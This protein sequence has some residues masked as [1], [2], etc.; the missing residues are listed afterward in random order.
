MPDP[1]FGLRED[2]FGERVEPRFYVA[3]PKFEA[4]SGYLTVGRIR[5]IVLV[6]GADGAGKSM[7]LRKLAA[8]YPDAVQH[9]CG[10]EDTASGLFEALAVGRGVSAKPE[11]A[12]TQEEWRRIV[13]PA[14]AKNGEATVL[15][16]DDV[17]RLSDEALVGVRNLA[18]L[19]S[20][21]RRLVRVI[22]TATP[23]FQKRLANGPLLALKRAIS[24]H[25]K[26]DPITVGD[27]GDY[28]V[29]RL[30]T[31][32]YG[33]KPLFDD[34]AVALIAAR[35]GGVPREIN[36]LCRQAL[37]LAVRNAD[38]IV[39]AGAVREADDKA[40]PAETPEVM[41]DGTVVAP[42]PKL[43]AVRIVAAD[44]SSGDSAL[45]L[46]V[47]GQSLQIQWAT[48]DRQVLQSTLTE[49]PALE[50]GS[51]APAVTD[52]RAPSAPPPKSDLGAQSQPIDIDETVINPLIAEKSARD[53]TPE[54]L[55]F[56][57]RAVQAKTESERGDGEPKAPSQTSPA[58]FAKLPARPALTAGAAIAAALLA[59]AGAA[60]YLSPTDPSVTAEA[61]PPAE[62]DSAAAAD[63]PA[64]A[65]SS[66]IA[67]ADDATDIA[68]A[69][70]PAAAQT[71]A[72]QVPQLTVNDLQTLEDT[73]IALDIR[74]TT[75]DSQPDLPVTISGLPQGAVLSAGSADG[76]SGWKLTAGQLDGL[77]LTPPENGDGSFE[78]TVT[79]GS[80]ID[81]AV[82][83]SRMTIDVVPAADMPTLTVA[84]AAGREDSPIPLNISVALTDNDGSETLTLLIAGVPDGAT[85]SAGT[86]LGGGRWSLMPGDH[87][88]LTITPPA[89]S[90]EDF[91]L[92]VTA[93]SAEARNGDAVDTSAEINVRVDPAADVPS[94]TVIDVSGREDEPIVFPIGASIPDGNGSESLTLTVHG[95]PAGARFSAGEP[96]GEGGW[97]LDSTD[98][99][100]LTFLP[101]ADFNG[102]VRLSIVAKS[103]EGEDIALADQAATITVAPVAD[104]P[105]LSVSDARG[106]EDEPVALALSARAAN[107]NETVAVTIAGFA[108]GT[109][110]SAGVEQAAGLWR[111]TP[112]ELAD[113][114]ALPPEN[115]S[116][117]MTLTVEA[118]STD[119]SDWTVVS[120]DMTVTI[121]PVA[122]MPRLSLDDASGKEDTPIALTIAAATTGL[123]ET[124]SVT[125]EGL[126][127]GA[128]LSAGAGD[129]SSRT[130]TEADLAD[131][132]LTPPPDF[133]GR[134]DLSVT[135][136]ATDQGETNSARGVMRITVEPV[137][138]APLL[139]AADAQGREDEPVPLR[140]DAKT[141]APNGREELTITIVGVP[142]GASLSAGR[143]EDDGRWIL[144][145]EDLPGLTLTPP[146]DS[147]AAIALEIVATSTE[148][149]TGESAETRRTIEVALTAVADT[150]QLAVEPA[151]GQEDSAVALAISVEAGDGSESL[152]IA[153]AGLPE[154][155]SLNRGAADG[156]GVWRLSAADLDGLTVTPS[157]GFAG[158]FDLT[159]TATSREQSSEES[160]EASATLPV[161]IAAVTDRPSLTVTDAAGDEDT[162][163]ELN[164]T[165]ASGDPDGS[166][167]LSLAIA[168]LPA[169]STLSKGSAGSEGLWALEAED[170]PG[171]MFTPPEDFS[172]DITLSVT[173]LS[174]ER[175]GDKTVEES[176]ELR[177][178]VAPVADPPMLAVKDAEGVAG[179]TVPL[180]IDAVPG[181]TDGSEVLV[182]RISGLADGMALSAG[183]S[184]EAGAWEVD[185]FSLAGL[186]LTTTED[187]AGSSVLTVTARS[188][189][190]TD[191]AFTETTLQV[192]LTAPP[193]PVAVAAAPAAAAQPAQPI[194]PTPKPDVESPKIIALIK[195]GD[196]LLDL[197]DVSSARLLFELAADSGSA[198]AATAVGKTYD[199]VVHATIGVIGASADP[200][201]AMAWYEKAIAGGDSEAEAHRE[202]L[203][204]WLNA[205]TD[206]RTAAEKV[207][208]ADSGNSV[209]TTP[210]NTN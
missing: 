168:G 208:A 128:E 85:L 178:A 12:R 167:T 156:D 29:H 184:I 75:G 83:S 130:L 126:P 8:D 102:A 63:S 7:L 109:I 129:G 154:G 149:A 188:R 114:R 65:A 27:V 136:S 153:I 11:S 177:I 151:S 22:M 121:E 108:E 100:G 56:V 206:L 182:V 57:E 175:G 107:A 91:T 170:L 169:G 37:D 199:P 86:H 196:T 97:A 152:E 210:A 192:T 110:L 66:A 198:R 34:A 96:D 120:D 60:Y 1:L 35:S 174:R 172:G 77:M 26:L 95:L 21:K 195:R 13:R 183:S 98:L 16:L 38:T 79:A 135:A 93:Q 58:L 205:S 45:G 112:E 47:D 106:V 179:E 173:A 31:A 143:P 203:A 204:A 52:Q 90:S 51:V 150:P 189:D 209:S 44:L 14:L 15:L 194:A 10:P 24:A 158:A 30:R 76:E 19:K 2:P 193:T 207:G 191:E 68:P 187:H 124:L 70:G 28:I 171:L 39:T 5:G 73:P 59:T 119:G 165:A 54:P 50:S 80:A 159:V 200:V 127:P 99:E 101:P 71:A 137:A 161:E 67:D 123:G 87:T 186:V 92:T 25:H 4:I 84:D 3:G 6:T 116:G 9:R 36:R 176:A 180:A 115:Y 146:A 202:A 53:A 105:S 32:G 18:D 155:A 162:A 48:F 49:A 55:T 82:T 111:L 20:G 104:P 89:N 78:L 41:G 42:V 131:L 134:I 113:L 142:T 166:E 46:T 201:K 23:A 88:G 164:I 33:G 133:N 144:G 141:G 190:G 163:I 139:E 140:I 122:D 61:V 118:T 72:V 125:V 197:R 181:D 185:P 117:T 157:D 64:A 94:L 103:S 138:D 62:P 17:G 69:A 148:P 160:A 81:G 40:A 145:P 147:D 74:L 132:T 43:L